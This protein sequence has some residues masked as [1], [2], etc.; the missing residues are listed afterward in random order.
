M[1]SPFLA[2]TGA[3]SPQTYFDHISGVLNCCRENV[4]KMLEFCSYSDEQK[5]A[6]M[7]ILLNA[8]QFQDL[9][10]LDEQNQIVFQIF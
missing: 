8:A 3:K 4:V 10:K 6:F 2:R 7:S 9:G 5:R 1:M